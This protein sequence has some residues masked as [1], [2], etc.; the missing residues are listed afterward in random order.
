MAKIYN[1]SYAA[2]NY[3]DASAWVCPVILYNQDIRSGAN[4]MP[5]YALHYLRAICQ[6][7]KNVCLQYTILINWGRNKW[8]NIPCL[9]RIEWVSG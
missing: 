1:E 7:R 8:I 2:I 9:L 4:L 3:V 6:Y 5:T